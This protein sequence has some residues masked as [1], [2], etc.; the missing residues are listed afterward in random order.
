MTPTSWTILCNNYLD[1]KSKRTP[2]SNH[3]VTSTNLKNLLSID[4]IRHKNIQARFL[5]ISLH[6]HTFT[7]VTNTLLSI[8]SIMHYFYYY[9]NYSQWEL[10]GNLYKIRTTLKAGEGTLET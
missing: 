2:Y 1:L 5:H 10:C 6:H 3:M 7:F 4:I 9:I 8:A